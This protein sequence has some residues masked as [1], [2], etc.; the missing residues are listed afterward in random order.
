MRVVPG[1]EAP[2]GK[3]GEGL[4]QKRVLGV[5]VRQAGLFPMGYEEKA[6]SVCLEVGKSVSISRLVTV[7]V[8]QGL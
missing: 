6:G 8:L 3:A 2:V 1:K 7:V 4:P 5:S